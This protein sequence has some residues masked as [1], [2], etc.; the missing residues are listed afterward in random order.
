MSRIVARS[1]A[2][3]ALTVMT[4]PVGAPKSSG[5]ASVP[6]QGRV[7]TFQLSMPQLGGRTRIIRVYLP[8]AYD[9]G[10][11]SYPVLYLQDAQ[12]LFAPGPFGDWLV[13]ETLDRLAE[14][15]PEKALIVV[16]VDN[17]EHRWDEYSPWVNP[18]VHDWVDSSWAAPSQG[19][20]GSAYLD[21]LA[22]T[23]KPQIDRKY[24]T[25]ADREHTGIGGSSMG[26]LIALYGGL[27]RPE[28][29]SKVMAMSTAVWFAEAGGPWLSDNRLV[30]F[31]GAHAPTNVRFYLDV[32]SNERSRDKDPDVTD[33]S[34]QPVSYP[35]AYVDGSEAVAEALRAAG[36][37][38]DNLRHLV[39]PGGIHNESA[40]SVR[41]EGAV[42]WLYQ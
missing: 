10:N 9:S 14:H 22:T 4:P 26:G 27:A 42:R 12:Q 6:M 38:G 28:V 40:W 25:L 2:L 23:L 35:R 34:N 20:E 29:F 31:A 21:F 7:E 24:R 30:Q 11:A 8:T 15:S 37:P 5:A 18:H 3:F 33:T 39:V 13:D 32:G 36:V 1:V 41:F 19:G 17:S 16:G